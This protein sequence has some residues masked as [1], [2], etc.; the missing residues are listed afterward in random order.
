MQKGTWLNHSACG[1]VKKPFGAQE[2]LHNCVI[3][4]IPSTPRDAVHYTTPHVNHIVL[5]I[6][7]F[8]K[9]HFTL[10][11]F[12]VLELEV[13]G[14][15]FGNRVSYMRMMPGQ[16]NPWLSHKVQRAGR[17]PGPSRV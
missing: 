12:V 1:S 15:D 10:I 8:S 3:L 16:W 7:N 5:S 4:G 13:S 6:A 9:I 2:Q 17:T 11:H 14:H